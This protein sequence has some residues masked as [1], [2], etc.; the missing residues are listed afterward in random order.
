MKKCLLLLLFLPILFSGKLNAQEPKA[1]FDISRASI[2]FPHP[3]ARWHFQV[4]A[5]FSMVKL[6]FDLVENAI[7]APLVNIHS[8]FGLPAGF[9]LEGDLTTL[10]VS[11]QLS[12]GPRWNFLYRNFSFNV[13][14]DVAYC[15]GRMNFAGFK[16]SSYVWINY[17]NLAVG[18]KIKD[19]ALT[20]KAEAVIVTS[21][22][23]KAGSNEIS[24]SRNFY[25]GTTYALYIEQ[26]LWKNNVFTIG[27]KDNCVKYYWGTWMLFTTFNRFYHIPELYF[28]W[29]L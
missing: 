4:A 17:P 9:S 23:S 19:I 5:G 24:H 1:D 18:Y 8:T 27:L 16:N 21:T 22:A 3:Y 2:R 6:P 29:V 13:G 11:N 20:L 25:N 10:V 15:Y 7:E 14:Y 12:L 26:R 28:S